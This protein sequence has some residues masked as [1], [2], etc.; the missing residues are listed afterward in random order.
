MCWLRGRREKQRGRRKTASREPAAAAA[1]ATAASWRGTAF[2]WL[3]QCLREAGHRL[4]VVLAG[5]GGGRVRRGE[6][7]RGRAEGKGLDVR[8]GGDGGRWRNEEGLGK[9]GSRWRR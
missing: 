4:H 9:R 1:F 2:P 8:V 3:L 6:E 7:M 5:R